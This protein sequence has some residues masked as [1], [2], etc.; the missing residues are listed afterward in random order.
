MSFGIGLSIFSYKVLLNI[1]LSAL[2]IG[3]VIIGLAALSNPPEVLGSRIMNALFNSVTLSLDS[4]L[5][6]LEDRR[7]PMSP[8]PLDVINLD[9][10][11]L[12]RNARS[13]G[14]AVYLPP[15]DDKAAV[16]LPLCSEM[17][18]LNDLWSAPSRV[19]DL[20]NPSKGFVMYPIGATLCQIIDPKANPGIGLE[21]ALHMILIDYSELCSWI[22]VASLDQFVVLE[23][24]NV[25]LKGQSS[26]YSK[27]L[28]SIPTSLSASVLCV[29]KQKSV[30]ILE[31]RIIGNRILVRLEVR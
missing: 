17:L 22:R 24:G 10:A 7:Y 23:L 5:G 28:G 31:E 4:I 26:K 30:V 29:I 19:S 3:S 20:K 15:K 11:M 25:K 8:I 1:P 12:S 16:F 18:D 21:K 13:S 2:G 14:R 27:Y 9:P 6:E